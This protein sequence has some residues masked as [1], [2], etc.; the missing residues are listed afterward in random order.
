MKRLKLFGNVKLVYFSRNCFSSY[1]LFLPD[2]SLRK[3]WRPFWAQSRSNG[4]SAYDKNKRHRKGSFTDRV[5]H[6]NIRCFF[7][8]W[9]N[10]MLSHAPDQRAACH[11]LVFRLERKLLKNT[12]FNICWLR[13]NRLALSDECCLW[14]RMFCF[15]LNI[16]NT[17]INQEAIL[18]RVSSWAR[19]RKPHTQF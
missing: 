8:S 10:R 13:H 17:R 9:K 19:A 15:A 7:K 1:F 2:I 3:Y 5:A 4:I 16:R 6:E 14:E 11:V 12:C 18:E